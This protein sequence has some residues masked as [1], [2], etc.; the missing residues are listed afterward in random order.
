MAWP[1]PITETEVTDSSVIRLQKALPQCLIRYY[2]ADF[3]FGI[4]VGSGDEEWFFDGSNL[5]Q[6]Q[7]KKRGRGLVVD[8]SGRKISNFGVA[9]LQT[10]AP[11]LQELKL[12]GTRVTDG[13][14]KRLA[15]FTKAKLIDLRNTD[16]TATGVKKLKVALWK[17]RIER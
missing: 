9:R 8:F 13:A 17:S 5:G 15:T 12:N 3:L 4:A 6:F 10:I 16:V 2:H 11:E 1:S 7:L 14:I